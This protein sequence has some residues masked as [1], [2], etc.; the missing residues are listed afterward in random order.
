MIKVMPISINLIYIRLDA[1]PRPISLFQVYMP[2]VGSNVEEVAA[3]YSDLQTHIDACAKKDQVIITG[4]FNAKIGTDTEHRSCGKFGLGVMNE[5]GQMLLDWMEDK[6]MIALNTCFQHRRGQ[7]YTWTSPGG[8]ISNQID[9]I[10]VRRCD[11]KDHKDSRV[12]R[13]A[14]CG[15]DH[16][17]KRCLEQL[18]CEPNSFEELL[19]MKLHQ[20]DNI[21]CEEFTDGLKKAIDEFCLANET[22]IKPWIDEV[23]LN[24]IDRRRDAKLHGAHTQEYRTLNTAVHNACRD[25]K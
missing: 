15:S 1:K 18:L 7:L 14:D 12:L 20:H 4:D 13:S 23:C 9:Y 3:V 21:S 17:M 11:L 25:A 22:I 6:K 10:I 19:K 8:T 16:E 2:T 24:L 5:R